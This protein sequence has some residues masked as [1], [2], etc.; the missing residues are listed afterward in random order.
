M[1]TSIYHSVPALRQPQTWAC[2]YTSAQ[3]V[4]GY[5]RTIGTAPWLRDPSEVPW[6]HALF[7]TNRGVGGTTG[8]RERVAH[9]LGLECT[10]MSLTN[11]GMWEL[12][13]GGP[14]IYAGRWPNRRSGHWVVI[15]GLSG[16]TLVINNPS[17]GQE[18]YDYNT[19]MSTVLI[20]TGE[21]PLIHA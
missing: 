13:H 5:H 2:W 14:V 1:N 8:E 6:V 18:S 16:N 12:L 11:E 19:F 4:V 3:M 9:A 17:R 10:F 21:R 15:V 20:Q 7:T